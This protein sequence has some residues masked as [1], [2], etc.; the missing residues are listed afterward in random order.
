[1]DETLDVNQNCPWETE[2]ITK[3]GFLYRR[4]FRTQRLHKKSRLPNESAFSLRKDKDEHYLSF[5]WA[6]YIDSEKSYL[7]LG[8][9][10]NGTE[11]AFL[12]MREF[13]IVKLSIDQLLNFPGVNKIQHEII[14]NGNPSKVGKPN[15]RSHCGVYLKEDDDVDFKLIAAQYCQDNEANCL[16]IPNYDDLEIKLANLKEKGNTT[17]FHTDWNFN[18]QVAEVHP[19]VE[20]KSI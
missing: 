5:N 16:R 11:T 3:N 14:F 12:N 17:P 19:K 1:M 9:S 20:G 7:H 13:S 8:I 18:E 6:N 10:H 15:N 2:I 4:V